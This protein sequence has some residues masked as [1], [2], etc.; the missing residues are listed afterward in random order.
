VNHRGSKRLRL[1]VPSEKSNPAYF[2]TLEKALSRYERAEAVEVN[3]LTGSL[4]FVGDSVDLKSVVAFGEENKLFTVEAAKANP[5]NNPKHLPGKVVKPLHGVHNAMDQLT[6]GNLDLSGLIFLLLL[7]TG[8]YQI[9][10]GNFG[11]P[12]WYTAFW[13]AFGVFTKQ[14]MEEAERKDAARE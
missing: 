6:G 11:A 7:G 4:L 12:P 13:Y 1:R 10:R 2:A 3:A 5:K 8:A 9:A 14:L